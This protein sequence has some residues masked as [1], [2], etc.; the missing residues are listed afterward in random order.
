MVKTS[1]NDRIIYNP[2]LITGEHVLAI[3]ELIV[4]EHVF[5]IL[6]YQR[7]IHPTG[8]PVN[9]KERVVGM[10]DVCRESS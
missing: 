3:K 5:T 6:N 8:C 10:E 9:A 4:E 1:I 2:V 7:C